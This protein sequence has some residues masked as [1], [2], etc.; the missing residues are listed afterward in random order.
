MHQVGI[1]ALNKLKKK[2]I[3]CCKNYLSNELNAI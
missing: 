2:N 3:F 1:N